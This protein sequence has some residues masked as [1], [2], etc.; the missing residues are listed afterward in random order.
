V[1]CDLVE[2]TSLNHR[3]ALAYIWFQQSVP[4]PAPTLSV[5]RKRLKTLLFLRLFRFCSQLRQFCTPCI[6]AQ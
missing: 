3:D 5:F 1:S 4:T 6:L 2:N